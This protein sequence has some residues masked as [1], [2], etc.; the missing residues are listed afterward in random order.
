MHDSEPNSL[1]IIDNIVSNPQKNGGQV[2]GQP[3]DRLRRDPEVNAE[4]LFEV[5]LAAEVHER[6]ILGES[7]TPEEYRTRFGRFI[8]VVARQFEDTRDSLADSSRGNCVGMPDF[9]RSQP[10]DSAMIDAVLPE[11]RYRIIRHLG[12]GG[13]GSVYLGE[14][15][16][17]RRKVAIKVA[18]FSGES[19]MKRNVGVIREARTL[20]QFSKKGIVQIYDVLPLGSLAIGD[21]NEADCDGLALVMEYVE[22]RSLREALQEGR[23]PIRMAV[24][25]AW[26]VANALK[27]IHEHGW[28]HGDLTPKNILLTS[29]NRP[30]VVDFGLAVCEEAQHVRGNPARGTLPYMSPEQLRG[31]RLD[32]RSDTWG[33]GVIFYE[34]L[35][36]KQAFTGESREIIREKIL[37]PE[38][39]PP[40]PT[41]FDETIP[42]ELE[43]LCL[44]CLVR[45]RDQRY[46][47]A[48]RLAVELKN[49][50]GSSV[51]GLLWWVAL[52]VLKRSISGTCCLDGIRRH[53][54]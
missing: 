5:F 51:A 47:S 29:A 23:L 18:H 40:P 20:S 33:L 14:D 48:G 31:V 37:D 16:L 34:M 15:L 6:Q 17:V 53:G 27:G 41:Q 54:K 30:V 24:A 9:A 50:L 10:S 44:K 3:L 22:G 39:G 35:S 13:F 1:S 4:H 19:S 46:A 2:D 26:R 8:D 7:P 52:D 21:A 12:S 11:N 36:G 32:G 49:W 42:G 38:G 45:D 28:Y 43:D 25:I